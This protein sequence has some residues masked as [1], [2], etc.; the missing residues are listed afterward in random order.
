MANMSFEIK[1]DNTDAILKAT[2]EAI[3]NALEIV[4]NKAADYAAGLAPVDTGNLKN[5]MTC[6]VSID[7]KAVYIGTDVEYAPYVEFGHRQEVGRYVPEIGKR[8]VKAYVPAK[9]FLKP[10]IVNNLEEYKGIIESEL[11]DKIK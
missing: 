7:E 2:D 8:L 1:T 5:S 11:R 6:D 10:A 3:Y 9:P 4:G